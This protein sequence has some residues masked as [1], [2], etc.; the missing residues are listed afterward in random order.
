[1]TKSITWTKYI[2]DT[3]IREGN[4]NERQEYIVR[5]RARGASIAEQADYLHLSIDQVNKD[6]AKIKHIYDETCKYC[7]NL[8]P[9]RK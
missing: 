9:R 1:M 8:P 7:S 2:L 5:S 4:L 6:I 3:F